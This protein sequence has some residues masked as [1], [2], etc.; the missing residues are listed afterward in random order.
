MIKN[1]LRI[2]KNLTEFNNKIWPDIYSEAGDYMINDFKLIKN[3]KQE[4]Y[5]FS[6]GKLCMYSRAP[7]SNYLIKNLNM[8]IEKGY[9]IYWVD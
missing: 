3:D 1:F 6:S 9:K 7:C 2:N 8:D 5:Y 4:L